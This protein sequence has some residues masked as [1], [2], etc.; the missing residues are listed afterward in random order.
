MA[1]VVVISEI[2][3]MLVESSGITSV[4]GYVHRTVNPWSSVTVRVTV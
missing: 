4:N 1:K 3:M 2:S